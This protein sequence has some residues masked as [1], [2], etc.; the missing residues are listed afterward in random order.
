MRLMELIELDP[1]K[2]SAPSETNNHD[3]EYILPNEIGI[4]PIRSAVAY[5]GTVMPLA[6][7]RERSKRLITDIT[8]HETV[9]GLLA[10]KNPEI[11]DPAPS[12][13]YTIGTAA[14]VLKVIRMPQGSVNV[15][16]HG[17]IRFRVASSAGAWQPYSL[18]NRQ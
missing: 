12:D 2:D 10:Q 3:N 16:V 14:S 4:L 18:R 6:V 5:P 11:E 7:G 13:L 15:V 1:K 8:P 9:F 17:M